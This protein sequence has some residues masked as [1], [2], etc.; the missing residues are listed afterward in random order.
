M[1]ES[2]LIF[3]QC[4]TVALTE[5]IIGILHNCGSET[6]SFYFGNIL[7]NVLYYLCKIIRIK[8]LPKTIR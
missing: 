1:H 3:Q 5:L 6:I 8:I 4:D 7:A 2:A